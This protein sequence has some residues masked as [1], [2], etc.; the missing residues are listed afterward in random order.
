MEEE[1]DQQSTGAVESSHRQQQSRRSNSANTISNH[2]LAISN[3]AAATDTCIVPSHEE[4]DELHHHQVVQVAVSNLPD[5]DH[6]HQ[7]HPMHHHHHHPHHQ[8]HHHHHEHHHLA[9]PLPPPLHL[10][11]SVADL[12]DVEGIVGSGGDKTDR[13]LLKSAGREPA[14]EWSE[15]ATAV[16]ISAFREKFHALD[17]NNFRSKDWGEVAKEVNTHCANEK[18]HKTQE[19]C[20]MKV[21]SLKKRYRQEKDKLAG[22]VP[23]KWPWFEALDELIGGSPKQSRIGSARKQARF[24]TSPSPRPPCG[25]L[26]P[27]FGGVSSS[28]YLK[29]KIAKV[30]SLQDSIRQMQ[31]A[32]TLED[33]I[34][35]LLQDF[36]EED[37]VRDFAKKLASSKY[38][39]ATLLE[40]S[41]SELDEIMTE[42][43]PEA[44]RGERRGFKAAIWSKKRKLC[45]DVGDDLD[46]VNASESIMETSDNFAK[47]EKSGSFVR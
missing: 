1:D 13:P 32:G 44:A 18:T 40:M 17:R 34:E 37:T 27:Y 4:G 29:K 26:T 5:Y 6:D 12:G 23:C 24:G 11:D 38:T 47:K 22:N 25:L 8:H 35:V 20:R 42:E 2:T 31:M 7:H 28:I 41:E 19:Q 16:L 15:A 21:D 39:V 3:V 30:V 33:N 46:M 9:P 10:H 14:T 36:L 45:Q 43:F